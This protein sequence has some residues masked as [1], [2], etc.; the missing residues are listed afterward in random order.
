V[1]AVT[2]LL[3]L[4]LVT[5]GLGAA[6]SDHVNGRW[7]QRVLTILSAMLAACAVLL[8]DIVH[9]AKPAMAPLR[10]L[11]GVACLAPVGCLMGMPFAMGLRRLTRIGDPTI[12]WAWAAN[13]FASV[14]GAPLAVLVSMELGSRTVFG[15]AAVAYLGAALLYGP[16]GRA[17]EA[18]SPVEGRL[19]VSEP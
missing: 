5:S 18:T 19:A 6:W 2:A 3:V 11:A 10:V 16:A 13:A 12:G 9:A 8:L 1:Y 17:P 14:A 4:L 7:G 15:L